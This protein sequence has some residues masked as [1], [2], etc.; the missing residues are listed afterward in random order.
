MI[1]KELVC[2]EDVIGNDGITKVLTYG[3]IYVTHSNMIW[4][5]YYIRNDLGVEYL[6]S[7]KVFVTISEFRNFKI[8]DILC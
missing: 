1:Y 8:D 2:I 7:K 6:Y 5:E 4:D 3:E